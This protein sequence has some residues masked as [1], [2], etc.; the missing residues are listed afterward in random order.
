MFASHPILP[1]GT[2]YSAFHLYFCFCFCLNLDV[3]LYAAWNLVLQNFFPM[4]VICIWSFAVNSS[5]PH[6]IS[7]PDIHFRT[8]CCLHLKFRILNYSVAWD[9]IPG[10]SPTTPVTA[11]LVSPP[12]PGS[13]MQE[14]QLGRQL[15]SI[16]RCWHVCAKKNVQQEVP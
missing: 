10:F 15:D 13:Q 6:E 7:Y 16:G 8:C 12:Y 5:P 14:T 2:S 3:K 9:F 4:C 1:Y 11:V